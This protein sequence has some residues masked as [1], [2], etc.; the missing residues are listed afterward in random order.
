MKMQR[1]VVLVAFAVGCSS[2]SSPPASGDPA[3]ASPADR[4]PDL[5]L[6]APSANGFQMVL[7]I[8]RGV[9]AGSTNEICT[10][11]EKIL[12]ADL[13]VKAARGFQTKTGHHVIV[14]YTKI[15][16][17]AGT[18]RPCTDD[19]MASF[20]FVIGAGGEGTAQV[21]VLPGNL[22]TH[23]P[24]GAQL[25][26]NHHYLNAGAAAIDAQSAV[27]IDLADPKAQLT[28][29]SALA[30]VDTSLRVPPGQYG[31]DVKCKLKADMSL[32]QM[33]PHM[34]RWGSH[35]RVDHTSGAT[36][37]RLFDLA[38]DPDYTF[39]PPQDMRDPAKPYELKTGDEIKVHCDFANDTGKDLTFGIEMCV[40]FAETVD[41][42][43][44]GNLA[45]DQGSW[46]DF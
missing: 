11:T 2:S 12:D 31:M 8:V 26:V 9:A 22:A 27:N 5:K 36:S 33:T 24:K 32:W 14:Y 20:R 35:I 6:E 21:N 10:W 41:T 37:N 39:H 3:T 28:R 42:K 16:Q 40:L 17:P 34:H 4:L 23:V 45:C 19:D 13:D 1:A 43:S 15:K 29:S 7:P 30:F 44:L 18:Q 38:W 25:V 46:G